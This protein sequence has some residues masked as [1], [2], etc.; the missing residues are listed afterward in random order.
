MC[1]LIIV[2]CYIKSILNSQHNSFTMNLALVSLTICLCT[3]QFV[4]DLLWADISEI[5]GIIHSSGR[6]L[7]YAK[8]ERQKNYNCCFSPRIYKLF[9]T[10]YP[11]ANLHL[12]A[13]YLNGGK[14]R[15]MT[16]QKCTWLT[17]D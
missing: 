8:D 5:L 15:Q 2:H 7:K 12:S 13:F 17:D 1:N 11:Y 14:R 9:S 10:N 4:G 6:G 16:V 3:N